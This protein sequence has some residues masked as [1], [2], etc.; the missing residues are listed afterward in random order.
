MR[1]PYPATAMR[2]Q[3]AFLVVALLAP[4]F[5]AAQSTTADGIRAL[6]RGDTGA[7]LR[8]LKP[9]ADASEPDPL[10]QFFVATLHDTYSGVAMDPVRACGL[11]LTPTR[12]PLLVAH[13][14]ETPS[15]S[16]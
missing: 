13:Q 3:V 2:Y 8:I 11:Y 15:N 6:A 10:A 16:G 7:A 5:A 14:E 4:S 1:D 9:L 12:P